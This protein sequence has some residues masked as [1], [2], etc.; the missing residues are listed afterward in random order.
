MTASANALAQAL[1]LFFA[2]FLFPAVVA[3]AWVKAVRFDPYA[4]SF[5]TREY[6]APTPEM[7][8][9]IRL[10]GWIV[11]GIGAVLAL[12]ACRAGAKGLV[13]WRDAGLT[14]WVCAL[15]AALGGAFHLAADRAAEAIAQ[16]EPSQ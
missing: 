13:P 12:A 6:I 14:L 7:P 5:F 2:F 4:M 8:G 11:I 10:F 16:Q 9:E 15:V 1:R 3:A